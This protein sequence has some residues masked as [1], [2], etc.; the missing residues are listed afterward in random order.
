MEKFDKPDVI[1][2]TLCL[3]LSEVIDV[4]FSSFLSHT[5]S[6]QLSLCCSLRVRVT[7]AGFEL[8]DKVGEALEDWWWVL[9][10]SDCHFPVGKFLCL[11]I[12][13][14]CGVSSL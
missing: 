3:I 12:S 9:S 6:C 4:L 10:S 5:N 11:P 2:S 7:E 1:V 13:P 14:Y 8:I